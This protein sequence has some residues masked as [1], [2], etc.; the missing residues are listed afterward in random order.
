MNVDAREVLMSYVKF[1][2]RALIVTARDV[3]RNEAVCSLAKKYFK[4]IPLAIISNDPSADVIQLL[5]SSGLLHL[6]DVVIGQEEGGSIS[7]V[8]MFRQAAQR[9]NVPSDL[10]LGSCYFLSG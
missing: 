3:T 6:F 5:T 2:E 4:T 7:Q 8:D 10:C 1:Y 9:L